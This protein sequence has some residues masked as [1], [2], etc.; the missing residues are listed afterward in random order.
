MVDGVSHPELLEAST[1]YLARLVRRYRD[2]E[3]I[4]AW[5]VEH[6]AVDPLGLEH[7]WRLAESFV[8]REVATVRAADS[9]RPILLNG[10]LPASTAV[11]L[12]QWWRTRDQGDSVAVGERLADILGIDSYPRH[13]LAS[14]GGW[15]VYVDG[16]F[17]IL[18]T[19]RRRRLL[20][21]ATAA[22]REVMVTEG[23][24]EPWESVTI[25]PNP[26]GRVPASCPPERII[27]NYH[28][29][30]GWAD[31]THTE[32]SGYLFWGAEY[33]VMRDQ[34]GDGSY[35]DAFARILDQS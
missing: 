26:S 24:A 17:G 2:R 10:F 21:R 11:L 32:L 7:S 15:G 20:A 34:H 19:L 29:W 28:D 13:A 14:L 6:E 22:G 9:S 31:R 23:Q 33:W 25:P 12:H 27:Q 18:P 30:L 16:A 35:L 3:S 4:I 5:Q 1:E 8:R